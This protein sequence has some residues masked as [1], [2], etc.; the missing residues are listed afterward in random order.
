MV[1]AIILL[2]VAIAMILP[3]A[4][5]IV[6]ADR[7]SPLYF[8]RRLGKDSKPFTCVKLQTMR[9]TTDETEISDQDKNT[10]RQTNIGAWFRDHSLDEL[11]QLV[12]IIT[13]SMTFIGPR[14]LHANDYMRMRRLFSDAA[15]FKQWQDLRLSV[16][17]GLSGWQQ[18]HTDGMTLEGASYDAA[19]LTRPT[20]TRK[21]HVIVYSVIVVAIG[22]RSYFNK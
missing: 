13:G 7:I 6:F 15:L 20:L 1:A 9:P 22:K 5:I 4:C 14:P 3:L 8:Q 12:N 21:L 18:V 11:P 10:L 16:R 2:P 17:P 19:Y